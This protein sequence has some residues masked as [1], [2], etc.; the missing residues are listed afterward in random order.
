MQGARFFTAATPPDGMQK[1][2]SETQSSG[3]QTLLHRPMPAIGATKAVL[4]RKAAMAGRPAG[5][6]AHPR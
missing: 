4:R 3:M 1:H 6:G 2:F 5:G